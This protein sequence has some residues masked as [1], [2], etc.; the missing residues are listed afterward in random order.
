[1]GFKERR[2]LSDVFSFAEW[3]D[4]FRPSLREDDTGT[5]LL[6]DA[7]PDPDDGA[8]SAPLQSGNRASKASLAPFCPSMTSD[9]GYSIRRVKTHILGNRCTG[10]LRLFFLSGIKP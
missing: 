10:R 7:G 3:T 4:R 8:W 6:S 2:N 9:T 1:M 5:D